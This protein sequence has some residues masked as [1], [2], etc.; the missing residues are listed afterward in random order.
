MPFHSFALSLHNKTKKAMIEGLVS[1]IMPTYNSGKFLAES[2]ESILNQT[3]KHLELLITD[4]CSSDEDTINLLEKYQKEDNRV[5]VVS[6]KQNSGP[7]VARNHS[8][9]RQMDAKQIGNTAGND[10]ENW[11]GS[12][13]LVIHYLR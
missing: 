13:L 9:E 1:V 4:D 3:Y 6:L 7:G 11:Q 12:M 2:I 10:D 8:I 5:R